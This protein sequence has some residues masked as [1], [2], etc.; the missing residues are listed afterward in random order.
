MPGCTCSQLVVMSLKFESR[1]L[2]AH[3]AQVYM[4]S[5]HGVPGSVV[6]TETD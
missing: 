4:L 6:S 3:S 1:G 2:G 5:M